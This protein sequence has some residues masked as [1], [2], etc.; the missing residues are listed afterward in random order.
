M[1]PDAFAITPGSTATT[2]LRALGVPIV[3]Q[4]TGFACATPTAQRAT[5]Q[6]DGQA[7]GRDRA[8]RPT[9]HGPW[10]ASALIPDPILTRRIARAVTHG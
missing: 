6:D 3:I 8:V 5:V 10:P 2:S 4:D 1:A 7:V 9:P